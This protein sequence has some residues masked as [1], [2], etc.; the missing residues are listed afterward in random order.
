MPLPRLNS[1]TPVLR[2]TTAPVLDTKAGAT[3]MEGG[4]AWM[5]KRHRVAER[6]GYRCANCGAVWV[7][8]RDE[9][10]HIVPRERGGSNDESNLQPLCNHP[11]HAEKTAREAAERARGGRI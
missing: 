4:S 8:T 10:D 3:P 9:I 11:C 5:A 1:K 7:S 6:Y 2:T